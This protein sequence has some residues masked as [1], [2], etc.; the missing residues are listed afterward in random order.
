MVRL[1]ASA[2]AAHGM[3]S[4]SYWIP[5]LKSEATQPFTERER[6]AADNTESS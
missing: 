1:G 4:I 5:R 6:D 2:M 3:G